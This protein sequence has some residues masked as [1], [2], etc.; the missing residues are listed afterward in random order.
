MGQASHAIY[1]TELI[2]HYGVKKIIRIGSCGTVCYPRIKMGD[3][4]FGVGAGTDSNMNRMKFLNL[5]NA[6]TADFDLLSEGIKVCEEM[7]E[8]GE[9]QKGV[10]KGN[11]DSSSN[12]NSSNPTSSTPTTPSYHVSRIFSSDYFYH[13]M[14]RQ[15][16]PL[17]QKF[18]YGAIEMEA[19]VLYALA[20]EHGAQA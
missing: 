6:A 11:V 4:V 15:L 17:M 1:V 5:D 12:P 18:D 8:T 2:T 20:L 10:K 14:E 7:A 19:A 13:P 9:L 16:Y 3:I